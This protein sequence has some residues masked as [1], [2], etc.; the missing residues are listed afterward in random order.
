MTTTRRRIWTVDTPEYGEFAQLC[1]T[2]QWRKEDHLP[3]AGD[4]SPGGK[5]LDALILR[6]LSGD[7]DADG[8]LKGFSRDQVKTKLRHFKATFEV[9]REVSLVDDEILESTPLLLEMLRGD[10]VYE[11]AGRRQHA[12]MFDKSTPTF[13]TFVEIA[14]GYHLLLLFE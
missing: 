9:A 7:K 10:D 5:A 2:Y 12:I 3:R 11:I 14:R 4:K 8:N 13:A 1:E 6:G